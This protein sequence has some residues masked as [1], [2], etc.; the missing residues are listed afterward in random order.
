MPERFDASHEEEQR[1]LQCKFIV[2]CRAQFDAHLAEN[3]NQ[4]I[5]GVSIMFHTGIGIG[6]AVESVWFDE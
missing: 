6:L 2:V 1:V 4:A 5:F 3:D